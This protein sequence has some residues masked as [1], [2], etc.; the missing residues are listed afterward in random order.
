M[1]QNPQMTTE[2]FTL[3]PAKQASWLVY[4]NGCELH[5]GLRLLAEKIAQ[6]EARLDGLESR[7]VTEVGERNGR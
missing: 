7:Q 4:L 6:V 5:E 2:E 3:L 1:K